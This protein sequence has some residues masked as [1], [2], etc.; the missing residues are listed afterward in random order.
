MLSDRQQ[1]HSQSRSKGALIFAK[2][3]SSSLAQLHSTT[4][5]PAEL[6]IS[7]S[8]GAIGAFPFGLHL[9]IS[10]RRSTYVRTTP[11]KRC[12]TRIEDT[13]PCRASFLPEHR[14]GSQWLKSHI[15]TGTSIVMGPASSLPSSSSVLPVEDSSSSADNQTSSCRRWLTLS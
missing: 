14:R 1:R 4:A 8:H 2:G 3:T 15:A 9:R 12:P 10:R 5:I 6:T 7:S 13:R 11:R